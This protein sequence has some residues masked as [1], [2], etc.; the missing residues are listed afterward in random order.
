MGVSPVVFATMLQLTN[1]GYFEPL[2]TSPY[3]AP[4]I[5]AGVVLEIIGFVTIW[6]LAKIKV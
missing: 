5:E 6:R 3:A 4:L 2:L 1:P